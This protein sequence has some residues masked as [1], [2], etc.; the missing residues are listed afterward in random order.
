MSRSNIN[1]LNQNFIHSGFLLLSLLVL[2][3]C[4]QKNENKESVR[5]RDPRSQTNSNIPGG[6][7]IPGQPNSGR[8]QGYV[9]LSYGIG[10]V[11]AFVSASIDPNSLGN[12]GNAPNTGILFEGDVVAPGLLQSLQT[13]APVNIDRSSWFGVLIYDDLVGRPDSTGQA[14]PPIS[15]FVGPQKGGVAS[16]QIQGGRA[17]IVFQDSYGAIILVGQINQ[18]TFEGEIQFQNST[19]VVG[20]QPASGTLGHFQIATCGFFRCQ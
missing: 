15:V 18:Q 6:S 16:G 9:Q 5:M 14:T 13:G 7:A 20:G 4:P 3:A 17:Q 11:Q 1:K 19:S 8:A 2:T 12:I 10:A